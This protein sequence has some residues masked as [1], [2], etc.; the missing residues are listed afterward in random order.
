[1]DDGGSAGFE[2][3]WGT[4]FTIVTDGYDYISLDSFVWPPK[5]TTAA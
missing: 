2:E 5:T 3:N 4:H 1:M